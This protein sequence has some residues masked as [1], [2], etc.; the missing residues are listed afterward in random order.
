MKKKT[1][2]K[3]LLIFLRKKKKQVWKIRDLGDF[4]KREKEK[5]FWTFLFSPNFTGGKIIG[6]NFWAIKGKMWFFPISFVR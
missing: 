6:E 5:K 3:N 4:K 2:K 1:L